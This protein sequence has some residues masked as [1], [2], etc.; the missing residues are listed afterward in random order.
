VLSLLWSGSF[1][2]GSHYVHSNIMERE[3]QSQ[4]DSGFFFMPTGW[5]EL[6]Q[7]A[8]FITYYK[9]WSW[10]CP[11]PFPEVIIT[12]SLK[13]AV[14]VTRCVWTVK[15]SMHYHGLKIILWLL[16]SDLSE[17][18]GHGDRLRKLNVEVSG[19]KRRQEMRMQDSEANHLLCHILDPALWCPTALK[20]HS[21]LPVLYC[22]SILFSRS[23]EMS[24]PCLSTLSRL[25][26]A[27]FQSW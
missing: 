2:P 18:T 21:H 9:Y 5:L 1:C 20:G 13:S 19:V 6:L 23:P 7:W 26:R 27:Q 16:P 10:I 12:I 24:K 22:V 3:K 14:Y 8:T 25:G 11:A 15:T 17:V 4:V